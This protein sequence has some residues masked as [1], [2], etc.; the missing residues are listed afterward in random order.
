MNEF[1]YEVLQRKRI[2]N[3]AKN[4]KNGSKSKKCSLPSDGMSHKQWKERN[5]EIVSVR[6]NQPMSWEQFKKLHRDSQQ[7]YICTLQDLYDASINGIAAMFE[8]SVNT[9]KRYTDKRGL[10]I[11]RN[12]SKRSQAQQE[13][14]RKFCKGEATPEQEA[15]PPQ[16]ADGAEAAGTEAP[17]ET[18]PMVEIAPQSEA[19]PPRKAGMLLN[20][21]TLQFSGEFDPEAVRNSLAMILQKGQRVRIEIN[22]TVEG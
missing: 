3:S 10:A 14:W 8:I 5:G 4:R 15:A 19:E 9:L 7:L 22:C 20:S 13:V 16:A 6:M 2:A 17:S 11:R 18:P 12:M 1:D 21:F